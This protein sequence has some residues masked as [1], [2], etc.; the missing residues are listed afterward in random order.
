MDWEPEDV[1]VGPLIEEIAG[2][3]RRGNEAEKCKTVLNNKK[4][5]S[6]RSACGITS[7]DWSEWGLP[8]RILTELR[9]LEKKYE[10]EEKKGEQVQ[11]APLS[12]SLPLAFSKRSP[13]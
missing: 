2:T 12:S 10:T 3:L 8:L 7:Q 1:L 4:I 6:L 5:T 9:K 13:S 11:Q